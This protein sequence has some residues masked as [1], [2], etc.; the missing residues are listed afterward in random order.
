MPSPDPNLE[1]L[2]DKT[3]A[4]IHEL[5]EVAESGQKM[6]EKLEKE[7]VHIRNL[8]MESVEKITELAELV[9]SAN[10]IIPRLE[11]KVQL[12]KST[13]MS[14]AAKLGE[15]A[16]VMDAAVAKK[17]IEKGSILTP[18]V[19]TQGQVKAAVGVILE[20]AGFIQS[21]KKEESK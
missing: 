1:A 21:Q 3:P 16:D 6:Y 13:A 7:N 20:R 10:E 17:E 11:G 9:E 8:L 19:K 18:D 12:W 5:I 15:V 14:L 4:R 2:L